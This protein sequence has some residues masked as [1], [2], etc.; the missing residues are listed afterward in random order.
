MH[1]D[2]KAGVAGAATSNRKKLG[3]ESRREL[4]APEALGLIL[5]IEMD[6][7]KAFPEDE[8]KNRRAVKQF[9]REIAM[10]MPQLKMNG[11]QIERLVLKKAV[12]KE[13]VEHL[14]LGTGYGRSLGNRSAVVGHQ[15]RHA[16]INKGVRAKGGGRKNDYHEFFSS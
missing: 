10:E 8:A 4:S 6:F 1:K 3:D 11:L 16:L 7:G 14:Q 5:K 12:Y 13:R 9:Y 2:F 15:L